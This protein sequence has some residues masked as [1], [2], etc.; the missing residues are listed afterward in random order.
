LLASSTVIFGRMCFRMVLL[1]VP[2]ILGY[3]D[4]H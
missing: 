3:A 1:D 4:S 2:G